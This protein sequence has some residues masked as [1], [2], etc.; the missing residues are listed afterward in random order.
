MNWFSRCRYAL[1]CLSC[2]MMI[3]LLIACNEQKDEKVPLKSSIA[4]VLYSTDTAGEKLGSGVSYMFLISENGDVSTVKKSGLELNSIIPYN[5]QIL[6]H[7][8]NEMIGIKEDG[9]MNHTEFKGCSAP[10]GYGQSSGLLKNQGYHY[11]LFNIGFTPDMDDYISRIRWGDAK[12]NYC[13]EL[14]SY[15]EATGHDDN[16]IYLL[17]GDQIDP[18][19]L[20]FQRVNIG[21]GTVDESTLIEL[22]NMKSDSRIMFTRLIPYENSLIGIFSN[23]S[24]NSTQL[25]LLELNPAHPEDAKIYP[26]KEYSEGTSDYFLYNKDSIHVYN[27]LI[28][29]VDGYGDVYSY[30]LKNEILEKEFHFEGY[31][32]TPMLQDEQVFFKNDRLFFFRNNRDKGDHQI[33]AY[34][35]NGDRESILPVKGIEQAI[36][37]DKVHIYD[38]KILKE[39]ALD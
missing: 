5:N 19:R 20:N 30:D 25:Q 21:D 8:K 16:N 24:Q 28:Y 11:S 37:R 38:F 9:L 27:G 26:L 1:F 2:L 22:K 10:S 12:N 6:L 14:G 35:L 4:S 3:L 33:E 15:I 7:Q 13:K 29:Y 23:S 32:R 18:T 39:S 36:G 34:S 17:S 31:T